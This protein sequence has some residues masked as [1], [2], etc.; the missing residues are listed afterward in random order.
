M[1]E[2]TFGVKTGE[3]IPF[4]ENIAFMLILLGF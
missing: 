3:N 4:D 2:S 1:A